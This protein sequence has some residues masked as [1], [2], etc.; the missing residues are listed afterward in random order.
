[1][2][3]TEITNAT[4]QSLIERLLDLEGTMVAKNGNRIKGFIMESRNI[5]KE[6]NKRHIVDFNSFVKDRDLEL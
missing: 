3:K 6:L 5:A 1:M 2:N 4:N